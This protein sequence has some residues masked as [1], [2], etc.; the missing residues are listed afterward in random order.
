[1]AFKIVTASRIVYELLLNLF[2]NA[3]LL[4]CA[5]NNPKLCF[6]AYSIYRFMLIESTIM[7]VRVQ[8]NNLTF[9]FI[10]LINIAKALLVFETEKDVHIVV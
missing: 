8:Y 10:F 2:T 1:M 7:Y 9:F 3:T 4:N 6:F 5:N